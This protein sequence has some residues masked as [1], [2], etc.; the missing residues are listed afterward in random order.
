MEIEN[1]GERVLAIGQTG[2][3]RCHS[4]PTSA[5][6]RGVAQHLKNI[7]VISAL[8]EPLHRNGIHELVTAQSESDSVGTAVSYDAPS[9]E[10]HHTSR[11]RRIRAATTV[12]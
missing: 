4:P 8:V 2:G 11:R 9:R 3:A 1:S 6:Y 5:S 12:G 10:W 7:Q